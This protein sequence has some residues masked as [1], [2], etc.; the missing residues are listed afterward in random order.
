MLVTTCKCFM[1]FKDCAY[2]CY[3]EYIQSVHLKIL[4]F[5]MGGA[6]LYTD[7]F[8]P[9]KTMRRKQNLASALGIQKENLAQPCI[10]QR[11]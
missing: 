1:L 5:P 10:F 3:C 2:F 6:Y 9:F 8:A 11:Q 7:I 4:G